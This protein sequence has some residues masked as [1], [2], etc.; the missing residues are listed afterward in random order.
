MYIYWMDDDAI[1]HDVANSTTMSKV[2][3]YYSFDTCRV[4]ILIVL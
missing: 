1:K 3:D 2:G 4:E